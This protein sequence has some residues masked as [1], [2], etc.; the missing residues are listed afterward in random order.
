MNSYWPIQISKSQTKGKFIPSMKQINLYGMK[1]FK[2]TLKIWR[3]PN[4]Q[5]KLS[6]SSR[7]IGSMVADVH[8]TLSFTVEFSLILRIKNLKKANW[9]CLWMFPNVVFDG[10]GWWIIGCRKGPPLISSRLEFMIGLQLFWV[11]AKMF[12]NTFHIWNKAKPNY[13]VY[14]Y[15]YFKF[16]TLPLLVEHRRYKL[17]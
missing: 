3:K 16:K 17:H 4:E 10:K 14:K 1:R 2:N 6:Y 5:G 12:W 8:R 11:A 13:W 15:V 9:E 7:Y